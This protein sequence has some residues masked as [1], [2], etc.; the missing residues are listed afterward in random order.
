M[1]KEETKTNIVKLPDMPYMADLY[2][3][4]FLKIKH[5]K[6]LFYLKRATFLGFLVCPEPPRTQNK[7]E[8]EIHALD[9][10]KKYTYPLG[11]LNNCIFYG[12]DA[13]KEAEQRAK[14]LNI[15]LKQ[16]KEEL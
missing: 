4:E 12:E 6:E 7:Y 8:V 2:I 3:I 9:K 11:A 16:N 1:I 13:K 15:E 5:K 10:H 14:E